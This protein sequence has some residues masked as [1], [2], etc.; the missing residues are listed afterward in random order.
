MRIQSSSIFLL[1]SFLFY[2]PGHA[3]N[4]NHSIRLRK[5]PDNI[6]GVFPKIRGHLESSNADWEIDVYH[7]EGCN[8]KK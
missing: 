5:L 8:G 4:A 6:F 7:H 1:K 3:N 2:C